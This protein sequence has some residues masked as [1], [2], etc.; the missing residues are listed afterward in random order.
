MTKNGFTLAEIM[1]TIVLTG[2]L[3]AI[4]IPAITRLEPNKNKI[5][6]KKAYATAET[7]ISELLNDDGLYPIDTIN[8]GTNEL[9][10]LRNTTTATYNGVLYATTTTTRP[11]KF[12]ELFV[13]KVNVL[14]TTNCTA[15]GYDFTTSDGIVWDLPID[16]YANNGDSKTIKVDVIGGTTVVTTKSPNC[17][18]AAT[19]PA[20]CD[21]TGCPNPDQFIINVTNNGKIS[22]TGTKELE[23]IGSDSIQ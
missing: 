23:Y 11:F 19:P 22:L 14:G 9:I 13:A 5:M 18:C 2:V 7:V 21:T 16:E 15:A 17:S 3:A 12:C 1:V 20:T 10:G 6:F 8:T 4:L